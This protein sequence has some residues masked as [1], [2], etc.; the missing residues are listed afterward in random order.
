MAK[1]S[2][3]CC[4]PMETAESKKQRHEWELEDAARTLTRAI[5]IR[6]DKKLM[7]DLRKWAADKAAAMKAAVA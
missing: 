4:G 2:A 6:K 3:A 5:E 7:A 1:N